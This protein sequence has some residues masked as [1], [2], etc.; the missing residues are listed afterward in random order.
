[1]LKDQRKNE[2]KRVDKSLV[3]A[4]CLCVGLAL[5]VIGAIVLPEP[6]IGAVELSRSRDFIENTTE[7]KI[8][9]NSPKQSGGILAD[10]EYI[11]DEEASRSFTDRLFIILKN[12]KYSSIEKAD[13]GIWKTKIVIYNTTHELRVYVDAESIYLEK[14]GSLIEYRIPDNMRAD[15]DALYTEIN[16]RLAS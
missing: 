4:I 2:K 10:A 9:L 1:M 16:E 7:V 6:I 14:N 11:M 5:A 12:V 15:Y 3:I 13:T 8:V